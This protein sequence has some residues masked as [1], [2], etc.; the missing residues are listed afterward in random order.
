MTTQRV[1]RRHHDDW[2]NLLERSGPFLT[3]PVLSRVWP[4][5]LDPVAGE[6]MDEVRPAFEAWRHDEAGEQ[7]PWISF[8]LDRLL[9]WGGY[10]VQGPDLPTGLQAVVPEHE[11]TIRADFAFKAPDGT[12][13]LVG[14]VLP[15]GPSQRPERSA[16]GRRPRRTAWRCCSGAARC[17]SVWPPT[18][19]G[20]RWCGRRL[21]G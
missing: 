9:D 4:A 17:R 16:G 2:L 18:D 19:A 13:R 11:A 5:G 3:V 6:I 21:R 10:L 12:I 7:R 14:M 20:G 8:V 15:P 1:I